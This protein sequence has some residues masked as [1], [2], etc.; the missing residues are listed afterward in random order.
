[1][2][3]LTV[4]LALTLVMAGC[5]ASTTRYSASA[6]TKTA[7]TSAYTF[8]PHLR[9]I[10]SVRSRI[11]AVIHQLKSRIGKTWYVYS[12][13]QPSGWD[14]SGLT[15]WAYDKLGYQL[16]HSANAQAHLGKRTRHPHAGDLVVFGWGNYYV[17]AAIYLGHNK[18]IHAGFHKGMTT[19]IISLSSPDFQGM[20]IMFRQILPVAKSPLF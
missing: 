3:R 8:Q 4:L 19:Q 12:G 16:P 11:P 13:W 5:S 18:V 9:H 17:H 14:C 6:E 1:M 10:M 7:T 2:K 20:K 15:K